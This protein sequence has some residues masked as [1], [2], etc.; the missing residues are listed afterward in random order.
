LQGPDI[1]SNQ[2]LRCK[3]TGGWVVVASSICENVSTADI[4][5]DAF[6]VT[7]NT[8]TTWPAA[9]HLSQLYTFRG[10]TGALAVIENAFVND[11]LTALTQWGA[12]WIGGGRDEVN[13]DKG[14][15][16]AFP[17]LEDVKIYGNSVITPGIFT[18]FELGQPD[19]NGG[20]LCITNYSFWAVNRKLSTFAFAV[21][22]V[23]SSVVPPRTLQMCGAFGYCACLYDL[24][25]CLSA[26]LSIV[27]P[28]P[29][30][31][32]RVLRLGSNQISTIP[33]YIFTTSLADF[34]VSMNQLTVLPQ[35]PRPIEALRIINFNVCCALGI[36]FV[37]IVSRCG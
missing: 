18:N 37:F 6:Y 16:W 29:P 14:L 30:P 25:A 17:P 4:D 34:D 15:F 9:F 35:P 26:N 3:K 19:N 1:P 27:P 36:A 7:K 32:A 31:Y 10:H 24:I 8:K 20:G 23:M 28:V 22:F 11:L 5:S 33:A 13:I 21:R 2:R 12:V